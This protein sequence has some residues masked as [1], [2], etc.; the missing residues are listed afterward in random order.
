MMAP[1]GKYEVA[2]HDFR[3][4][5]M[6]SPLFGK[7]EIRGAQFDTN[8]QEFREAMSF[9]PDSR[10][11]AS[12][13]LVGAVPSP[14]SRVVVF[15]FERKRQIIVHDQNPGLVRR[16]GWS[17]SGRLTISTW[18]NLLGEQEHF[19]QLPAPQPR[20]FWKRLFG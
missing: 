7:I 6:G 9:S 4:V 1:N 2:T 3:E 19:W 10:F 15:D 12:A 13:Q 11:L 8:S 20:G 5:G 16:L 14:H 17:P 18:A